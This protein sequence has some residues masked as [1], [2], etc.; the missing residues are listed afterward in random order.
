M[1]KLFTILGCIA[2]FALTTTNVKA[3]NYK[4][5]LG[6]GID[7]GDGAT[8]VGPSV[9]HHFSPKAAIQ[10]DVLFGGNNQGES[11]VRARHGT[12]AESRAGAAS[13]H[14]GIRLL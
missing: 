1:K 13:R 14:H 4:T 7:F 6:L 10:G 8:L 5:G 12:R 9:R 3:Q 11:G 2:L